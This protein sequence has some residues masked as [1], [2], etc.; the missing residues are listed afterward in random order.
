MSISL[1]C[2]FRFK[3]LNIIKIQFAVVTFDDN[4]TKFCDDG[5]PFGM[6][7]CTCNIGL[8]CTFYVYH[9]KIIYMYEVLS[10]C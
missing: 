9:K 5:I 6:Q 4:G 7:F 10:D 1:V 3:I 8:T 2:S